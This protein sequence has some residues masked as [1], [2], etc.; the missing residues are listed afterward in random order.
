MKTLPPRSTSF[1]RSL[2]VNVVLGTVIGLVGLIVPPLP[3]EVAA[4]DLPPLI[5]FEF[6]QKHMGMPFRIAFYAHSEP[7]ANE[8]AAAAFDRIKQLDR[9][10]SD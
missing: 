4:A 8:A 3:A 10:M 9:T 7:V 1:C 5:R 6:T 2:F